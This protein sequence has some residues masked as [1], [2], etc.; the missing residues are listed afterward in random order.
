MKRL[1]Y[2]TR[3]VAFGLSIG[4]SQS[5]D[6]Q[7]MTFAGTN[8]SIS[9]VDLNEI[10]SIV[11][12]NHNLVVSGNDCGEQYFNVFTTDYITLDGSIGVG[13][14]NGNLSFWS[15]FPSPAQDMI[16]LKSSLKLGEQVRIYNAMGELLYNG[17]IQGEITQLNISNFTAGV[18]VIVVNH[19]SKSFIKS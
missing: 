17:K 4:W 14:S 8:G 16:S 11:F 12:T 5:V 3:V 9:N 15:V 19:Q 13:N 2:L 7:T 1:N 6:A 10:N 18:Y